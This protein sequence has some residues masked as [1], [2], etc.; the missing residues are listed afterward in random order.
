M[1]QG[2]PIVNSDPRPVILRAEGVTKRFG[3]VVAVDRVDYQLRQ[4]EVAGILGSNGAGKTSFFNLLTGYYF[5]TE[6]KIFYK[7]QDITNLTPQQRVS[8][9]M[10]RTFQ[11]TSTFDNLS[12]TDNLVLSFFRA[13][14]NSS[15][16]NL[17]FST[18][19]RYRDDENIHAALDQF[20]LRA[21][22]DR[23][24]THLSLGE[25]RR[26]EIAM[27]VIAKPEVL[28]LDEPLAGLAE[29]EIKGVLDVLRKQVGKQTILI[30][31][32]KISHVKDFLERLIVMHEGRIIAD[33]GYEECLRHPEVRKSYWQIDTPEEDDDQDILHDH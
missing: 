3:P 11:L 28:L 23:L 22:S 17:F 7:G 33:G 27:A 21:L 18:R 1:R 29:P 30:V 4:H 5:P 14:R 24:V 10:M 19:K 31:E 6:G 20:N 16:L 32:H 9:G 2:D 8:L 15:L 26:M 12:V 13:H 25:K